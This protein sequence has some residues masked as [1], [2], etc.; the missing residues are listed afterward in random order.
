MSNYKK[1]LW[2]RFQDQKEEPWPFVDFDEYKAWEDKQ[3]KMRKG[4]EIQIQKSH[5]DRD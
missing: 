4:Y 5:R 1:S 2:E 3:E